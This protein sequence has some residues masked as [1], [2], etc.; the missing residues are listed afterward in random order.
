MKK[1]KKDG[2]NPLNFRSK[3]LE[4]WNL[5]LIFVTY[6]IRVLRSLAS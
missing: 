6:L 3:Y 2:K 5:F 1:Q 4:M